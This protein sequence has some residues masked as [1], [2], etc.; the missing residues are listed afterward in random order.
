MCVWR[1]EVAYVLLLNCRNSDPETHVTNTHNRRRSIGFALAAL[2]FSPLVVADSELI[3]GIFPRRDAIETTRMYTPLAQHLTQV[4]GRPVRIETARDFDSFWQGVTQK[5]FDLV[6]FNQYEYVK[7]HKTYN[8]HVILKNVEFG[9]ATIAGALLVNKDAGINTLADL[10]GKKI[11]FGGGRSAFLAY[12]VNTHMLRKA[13]LRSGDYIEDFAKSPPNAVL[14]TYFGQASA[15]GAGAGALDL[16]MIK[17]KID[18]TKMKY[19]VTSEPYANLP[20]AVKGDMPAGQRQ[21]IQAALASLSSSAEGR[22]ILAKAGLTGLVVATDTEYDS[23]R[24]IIQEVLN[25]K[26]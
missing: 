17:N 23:A 22:A 7:S 21:R 24:R 18:V 13:G 14:A 19:L 1:R 9:D 16:T 12:I 20:W 4:L 11:V 2:L 5:R 10:K 25:E 6:H 8:Y 26:Y 15:G 3:M